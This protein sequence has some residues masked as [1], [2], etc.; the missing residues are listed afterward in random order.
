MARTRRIVIGTT[1]QDVQ[2]IVGK[3][4]TLADRL[5]GIHPQRSDVRLSCQKVTIC[6]NEGY[7]MLRTR[8]QWS[9]RKKVRAFVQKARRI[10]RMHNRVR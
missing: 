7:A 6:S 9:S 5:E 3:L 8:D 10:H 2:D 4:G 1:W